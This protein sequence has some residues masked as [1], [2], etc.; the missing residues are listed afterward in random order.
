MYTAERVISLLTLL[1]LFMLPSFIGRVFVVW[2]NARTP[3]A[4]VRQHMV[5]G[6][7]AGL[8]LTTL[9][10]FYGIIWDAYPNCVVWLSWMQRSVPISGY[11]TGE[12]D[13]NNDPLRVQIQK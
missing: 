11:V 4:V 8:S 12:V 5:M 10:L 2:V 7:A 13:V 9:V 6:G 3:L 1:S